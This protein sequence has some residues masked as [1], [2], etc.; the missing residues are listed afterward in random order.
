MLNHNDTVFPAIVDKTTV[1]CIQKINI[2]KNISD[3]KQ[4]LVKLYLGT[5]KAKWS[6]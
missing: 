3:N 2:K 6:N 1:N 5:Q 4:N